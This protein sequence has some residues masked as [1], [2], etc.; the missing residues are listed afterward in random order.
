VASGVLF[1]NAAPPRIANDDSCPVRPSRRV[2]NSLT[3]TL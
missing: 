3:S 2:A 1:Q